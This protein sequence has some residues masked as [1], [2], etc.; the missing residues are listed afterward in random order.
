MIPAQTLHVVEGVAIALGYGAAIL[1]IGTTLL[2]L[3]IGRPLLTTLVRARMDFFGILCLGFVIGQGFVGTLWLTISLVGILYPSPVWF[4]CLAGWVLV[5][6]EAAALIQHKIKLSPLRSVSL[7]VPRE[8]PWYY[9][10][11][12]GIALIT[13]LYGATTVLPPVIDDALKHYLVWSKMIAVTHRIELQPS[14]H[15]YY[16]LLPMQVEMHWAALFAI[17]NETAVTVWDYIC[18]LNF[19]FG[20]AF[21]AWRLTASRPVASIAALM[22]VSTPAF[23]SMMGGGKVDNA[24]AQFGIAAC[25]WMVLWPALGRRAVIL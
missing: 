4:V 16:G 19:L 18:A 6:V 3:V 20:T 23:Y 7:P 21:L 14:L 12:I 13:A 2:T 17:S 15:P 11:G 8:Q 5:V 24:S 1:G 22:M 10:A 25:L 9:Y